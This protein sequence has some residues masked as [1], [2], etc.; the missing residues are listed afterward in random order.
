M[1]KEKLS[2]CFRTWYCNAFARRNVRRLVCRIYYLLAAKA[3]RSLFLH[4][5][6]RSGVR[7]LAVRKAEANVARAF[8]EW[9]DSVVERRQYRHRLGSSRLWSARRRSRSV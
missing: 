6:A 9:C 5:A 8:L 2:K 7:Q 4:A 1:Q 3:F